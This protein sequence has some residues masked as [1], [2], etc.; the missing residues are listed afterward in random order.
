MVLGRDNR[1]YFDFEGTF[2]EAEV[3]ALLISDGQTMLR[4]NATDS[5]REDTPPALNEALLVGLSSLK[6]QLERAGAE[7]QRARGGA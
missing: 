5:T 3:K 2:G 1:A 6:P 4:G 7:G